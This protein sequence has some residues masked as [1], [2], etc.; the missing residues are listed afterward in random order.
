MGD[1]ANVYLSCPGEGVVASY[2]PQGELRAFYK[3]AGEGFRYPTGVAFARGKLYVVNR[4]V[5]QIV[6]C[7]IPRE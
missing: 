3:L 2:T 1:D 4:D 5:K 6:I 7:E